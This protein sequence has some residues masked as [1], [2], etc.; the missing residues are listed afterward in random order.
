M[1]HAT[2]SSSPSFLYHKT[3]CFG[4]SKTATRRIDGLLPL[5]SVAR[6]RR[7]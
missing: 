3:V 7:E 2:A 5:S 1:K 6:K 4:D